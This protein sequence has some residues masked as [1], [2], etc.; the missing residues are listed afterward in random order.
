LYVYGAAAAL[1]GLGSLYATLEAF[2]DLHLPYAGELGALVMLLGIATTWLRGL[3][4]L[5]R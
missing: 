3:G 1:A 5:Y 2:A 4:V